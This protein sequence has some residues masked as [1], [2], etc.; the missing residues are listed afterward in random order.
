MS[1]WKHTCITTF[2]WYILIFSCCRICRHLTLGAPQQQSPLL[3]R[4]LPILMLLQFWRRQ[5][6]FVRSSESHATFLSY[7]EIIWM[8]NKK[9]EMI[10]FPFFAFQNSG[11]WI[12][13]MYP[14]PEFQYY[15]SILCWLQG[16]YKNV[17][18]HAWNNMQMPIFLISGE[19]TKRKGTRTYTHMGLL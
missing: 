8:I 18:L 3:S 15:F 1:L 13:Y 10:F 17:H 6:L 5:M 2:S 14:S 19:D 9:S 7:F 11:F 4:N 12:S 16:M